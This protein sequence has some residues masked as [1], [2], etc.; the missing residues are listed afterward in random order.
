M[1]AVTLLVAS[2][3]FLGGCRAS[4]PEQ[5]LAYEELAAQ[6]AEVAIEYDRSLLSPTQEEVLKHLVA[7][8][9]AIDPI[10][11]EQLS[12]IALAIRDSL[13]QAGAPAALRRYLEI[14]YGP[15]DR[16]AANGPFLDVEAKPPGANLYPPDLSKEAFEAYLEAHP[17]QAESLR[18]EYTLVRR[19]DGGL[20]AVPYHE[21]YRSQLEAAARHLRAAANLRENASLSNY[22]TR[23]AQALLS[24]EYFESDLAWLD[25]KDNLLDI[26]IG[27]IEVYEDQ[28]M[29]LKAAFESRVMIKDPEATAQLE[30]YKAHLTAL[31]AHLPVPDRYKKAQVGLTMPLEV[32]NVVYASGDANAGVKAIAASLPNDPRVHEAKGSKKQIY[33]NILGAKFSRILQ[34]IAGRLLAPGMQGLVS[35]RAFL[36][37]VLMHELA[38]TLGPRRVVGEDGVPVNQ[39]LKDAYSPIEEAKADIVGQHSLAYLREEGVLTTEEVNDAYGAHLASIFRAIRFGATSAHG[40]AN[41]I[42]LN[43][44]MEEGAY[45]RVAPEGVYFVDV[46]KVPEAVAALARKLLLIEGNG[47]YEAAKALIEQYGTMRPETA[48]DL[49]RLEGIPVDVVLRYPFES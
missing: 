42:E 40:V 26:V 10:F 35:V 34:P 47:D 38:H 30:V 43:F 32:V 12:P 23:R 29:G 3:W 37:N 45:G 5:G 13:E 9:R 14:N 18:S 48:E 33:R 22:L 44:L 28:L 49:K 7:A 41:V 20:K 31:E 2:A 15:Y 21:A 11:W 8:A 39:A 1:V 46:S 25:L 19:A 17:D 4:E 27:P 24:G 6:Y 16:L 36:T